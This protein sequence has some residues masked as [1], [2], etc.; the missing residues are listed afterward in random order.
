MAGAPAMVARL[1]CMKVSAEMPGLC[2]SSTAAAAGP[3]SASKA[4][5]GAGRPC[6]SAENW[7][8]IVRALTSANPL[9]A[10][11]A[12]DALRKSDVKPKADE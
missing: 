10:G 2:R 9:V 7:P 6:A 12:F 4:R 3:C 11:E 8:Y 1:T 5:S